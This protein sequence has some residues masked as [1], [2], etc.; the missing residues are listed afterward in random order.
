MGEY[1]RDVSWDLVGEC[2]I[3]KEQSNILI[4]GLPL[5]NRSCLHVNGGHHEG[6]MGQLGIENQSNI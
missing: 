2:Q 4:F 1:V 5:I 6:I 3:E